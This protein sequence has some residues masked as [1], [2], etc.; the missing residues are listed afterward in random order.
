M[1]TRSA[2]RNELNPPVYAW[3]STGTEVA[4]DFDEASRAWMRN[5]IKLTHGT[6]KYQE[7]RSMRRSSST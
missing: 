2:S 3:T 4:I 6:Y 7:E 1:K 5:K